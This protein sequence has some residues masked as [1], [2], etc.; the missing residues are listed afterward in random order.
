MVQ[1]PLTTFGQRAKLLQFIVIPIIILS[2]VL[3]GRYNNIICSYVECGSTEC[4]LLKC[5][6]TDASCSMYNH[7]GAHELPYLIIAIHEVI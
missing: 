5:E 7:A 1:T 6:K 2:I 3:E 4:V